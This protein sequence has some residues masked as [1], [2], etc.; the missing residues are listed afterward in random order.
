MITDSDYEIAEKLEGFLYS[1]ALED[2]SKANMAE[3]VVKM[4][5]NLKKAPL[6][7]K[8]LSN[9]DKENKYFLAEC[10]NCG[11]WGS[12][13][14]LDGGGAIGMTGDHFDCTCPVCGKA[15]PDEKNDEFIDINLLKNIHDKL[16]VDF[17]KLDDKLKENY[18]DAV[19]MC[20]HIAQDYWMYKVETDDEK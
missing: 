19:I 1:L 12:S 13:A 8:A 5:E 3:V 18:S 16:E 11:W 2:S 15:D 4:R 7:Y 6:S 20:D 14:L 10:D 9:E 17:D